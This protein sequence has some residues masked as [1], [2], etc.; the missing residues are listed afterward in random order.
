MNRRVVWMPVVSLFALLVAAHAQQDPPIPA[1]ADPRAEVRAFADSARA[2]LSHCDFSLRSTGY[3]ATQREV[4]ATCLS[5]QVA[6]KEKAF[7]AL[8]KQPEGAPGLLLSLQR[9][10]SEWRKAAAEIPPREG[11]TSAAYATRKA[12]ILAEVDRA[13]T[14]LS[15]SY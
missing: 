5:Q 14:E 10:M 8:T 15:G 1:S 2:A 3:T 12:A 6:L 7:E 13:V 11:E 4:I 9:F